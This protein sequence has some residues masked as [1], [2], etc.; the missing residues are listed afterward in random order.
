MYTNGEFDLAYQRFKNSRGRGPKIYVYHCTDRVPDTQTADDKKSLK[1]F[2][3]KLNAIGHFKDTYKDDTELA[4]KFKEEVAKLFANNYIHYG[5]AAHTLS[6]SRFQ[7]APGYFIGRDAELAD[8][9]QRLKDG[10]KLMLI[11]A[12]GGIGKT[13]LAAKYWDDSLYEYKY[14]AWLFCDTGILPE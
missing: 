5:T 1:E 14:N 11:N 2:E 6:L 9:R 4:A 3:A 13:S 7:A 10:K 12:D 8:I